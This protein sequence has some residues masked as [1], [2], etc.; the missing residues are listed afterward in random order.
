ML[1]KIYKYCSTCDS[2]NYLIIISNK[3]IDF[4]EDVDE[5]GGWWTPDKSED[6]YIY[7]WRLQYT[8]GGSVSVP[9][10][11]TFPGEGDLKSNSWGE[12]YAKVFKKYGKLT[13]QNDL[14]GGMPD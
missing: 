5:K 2:N 6:A 9:A 14:G 1:W 7:K 4:H 13:R 11:T 12:W 10:Q 3:G 8:I